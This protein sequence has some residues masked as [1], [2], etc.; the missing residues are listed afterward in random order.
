MHHG[1]SSSRLVVCAV[2]L[3]R[4]RRLRLED[5][6]C[7]VDI[8]RRVNSEFLVAMT[9]MTTLVLATLAPCMLSP[10]VR[11]SVCP[12]VTSRSFT[13]MAERSS[14]TALNNSSYG[15]LYARMLVANWTSPISTECKMYS[16]DTFE[17]F[18]FYFCTF[19]FFHV[20]QCNTYGEQGRV[21][22]DMCST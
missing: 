20:K 21:P 4:L 19:I 15:V 10:S 14:L 8:Q 11:L 6:S 16:A 22:V 5:N 12:F 18:R 9:T 3:H 7:G 2:C 1:G 13:K 17:Q